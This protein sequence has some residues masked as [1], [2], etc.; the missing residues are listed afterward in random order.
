MDLAV[1]AAHM[2]AHGDME[3]VGLEVDPELVL[4]RGAEGVAANLGDQPL[5]GGPAVQG[6]DIEAA[7]GPHIGKVVDNLGQF[8]GFDHTG[9]IEVVER[10]G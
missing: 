8:T 9:D 1:L 5:E 10:I 6:R 7:A 2:A 4:E 3:R